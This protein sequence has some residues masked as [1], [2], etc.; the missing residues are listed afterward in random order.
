MNFAEAAMYVLV[1]S[2][3][4]I[5]SAVVWVF[6]RKGL[7]PT[8]SVF[9]KLGLILV[10]AT[11]LFFT[12]FLADAGVL[13][14]WNARPP[15][16]VLLPLTALISLI[17]LNRTKTFKA[18][19]LALPLWLP[20]LIQ[21][22]RVFVEMIL[23]RLHAQGDAPIQVTFEGRNFDIVFGLTAPV[24]ALLVYR[25]SIPPIAVL[26]WNFA[27]VAMLLNI[28][29]TAA[30]SLPGPLHLDWPGLPFTIISTAP[31]VWIP[32]FLAPMAISLHVVSIRQ[33]LN[34][35]QKSLFEFLHGT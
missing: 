1:T 4:F 20:I 28:M 25:K 7:I 5:L 32:A 19:L 21:F 26:L 34:A 15:R 2:L 12:K 16:L 24:I 22:Y 10:P 13:S 31:F 33:N 3:V 29:G 27:G 17:L 35:M 14:D 11:W 18:L 6:L 23:W 9:L 30:T 8:Q